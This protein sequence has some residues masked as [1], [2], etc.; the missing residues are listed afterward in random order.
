MN[1]TNL[2][3]SNLSEDR[4]QDRKTNRT[5][6]RNP[7]RNQDRTGDQIQ[8]LSFVLGNADETYSLMLPTTDLVEILNL[9]F[10]QIT[11]IP[12][13]SNFVMGVCNWRG[14]VV[15]VLDLAAKLGFEPLYR[16]GSGQG[17][18][19]TSCNVILLQAQGTVLGLAVKKVGQMLWSDRSKILPSPVSLTNSQIA[20]YLQ[21]YWPSDTGA[22]FLVLD[23]IALAQGLG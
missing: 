9:P 12:D 13:T 2:A 3:V 1:S 20:S 15:W 17:Y 11:P 19:Q 14:E 22:T 10:A 23:S 18:T 7:A 16:Q 4:I 5:A 6:T 8:Y 21:G